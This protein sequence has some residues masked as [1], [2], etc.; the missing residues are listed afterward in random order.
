MHKK[1]AHF[2]GKFRDYLKRRS[3]LQVRNG[4][5]AKPSFVWAAPIGFSFNAK[6]Q[7]NSKGLEK[8]DSLK[9]LSSITIHTKF[10][11]VE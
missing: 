2:A 8:D 7:V 11:I 9:S 10:K 5:I 6:S 1:T 4:K 3:F